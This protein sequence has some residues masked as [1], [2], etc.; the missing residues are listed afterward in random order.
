MQL[1]SLAAIDALT[2]SFHP[3]KGFCLLKSLGST[4]LDL[5]VW[6]SVTKKKK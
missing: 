5:A 1:C 2:Y 4:D 6:S 3:R